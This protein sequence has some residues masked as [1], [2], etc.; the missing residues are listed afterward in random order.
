MSNENINFA[1]RLWKEFKD[2]RA[3]DKLGII[4]GIFTI[5][6][7]SGVYFYT[8]FAFGKLL[9]LQLWGVALLLILTTLLITTT[10]LIIGGMVYASSPKRM[11]LKFSYLYFVALV[12]VWGMG[13]ALISIAFAFY[14]ELIQMLFRDL[15]IR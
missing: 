12:L 6:G 14:F 15:S 5:F 3:S 1:T 9:N 8:N 11:E 4:S 13:L 10:L 2:G 7:V